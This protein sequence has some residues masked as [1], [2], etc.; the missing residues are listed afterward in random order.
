N[1]VWLMNPAEVLSASLTGAPNT[2]V[3]PFKD[4]IARGTLANI[5]IIDSSTITAKTVILMDAAD[6]VSV[7][8]GAPRFDMS[9]SATIHME[10]TT[11]LELVGTGSPGTVASPQRSLFQTDSLALR[12]VMPLNW[13]NRRTG[14]VAYT[15][16]VTW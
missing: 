11:P 4:E 9:D 1:L 14:T 10:D 16:S 5:P 7:G 3:Y 8:G 2:G 13:A 6:F 12:M 15:T